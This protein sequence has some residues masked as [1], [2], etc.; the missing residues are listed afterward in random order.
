MTKQLTIGITSFNRLKYLQ[1]LIDSLRSLNRDKYEIIVVDNCSSE[2]GITDFLLNEK[3]KNF[4]DKLFLR[5]IAERNWT[6]DEYIAKNIII[7]NSESDVILFLQDDLQF[8]SNDEVLTRLVESFVQTGVPCCEVNAIRNSTIR[9]KF[10]E[11]RKF[12]GKNNI[13]F[14]VPVD[15][16]F[17]TMGLF[18]KDVFGLIGPY[19]TSWPQVQEYWGKSED[20]YDHALKTKFPK[21]QLNISTWVPIFAPIWNDPRGGYAFIRGD[22]RYGYYESPIE[23]LY[24]RQMTT[25]RFESYQTNPIPCSFAD[26]CNPIGWK[27]NVDATGDQIKFPQSSVMIEGPVSNF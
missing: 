17:H 23:N 22:K 21:Q 7:E 20:W 4:I 13:K 2:L 14:W 10:S 12:I 3:S 6:N 5:N 1:P 8:I 27:F 19:P 15:N 9:S 16:H 11:D 25:D 26:V 18:R 24:Y